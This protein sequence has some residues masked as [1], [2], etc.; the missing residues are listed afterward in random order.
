MIFIKSILSALDTRFG[1]RRRRLCIDVLYIYS[2]GGVVCGAT[3]KN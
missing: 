3:H 1:R 2:W